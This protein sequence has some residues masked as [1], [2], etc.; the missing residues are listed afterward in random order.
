MKVKSS[1]PNNPTNIIAVYVLANSGILLRCCPIAKS[2]FILRLQLLHVLN[3][4]TH[5]IVTDGI[6]AQFLHRASKKFEKHLKCFFVK[7]I[8]ELLSF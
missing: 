8:K 2:H 3:I 6:S 4:G 1:L 7:S 5:C